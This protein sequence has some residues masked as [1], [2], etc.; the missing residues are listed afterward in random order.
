MAKSFH[1]LAW[2]DLESTNIPEPDREAESIDFSDVHIL[3][4]AVLISNMDLEPVTGYH[5]VVRMTP[6]AGESLRRNDFVRDMHMKNDLIRDCVKSESAK[7]LAEID[8]DLD[9]MF[10]EQ[11]SFEHGEFLIAGSGVSRFDHPLIDIRMPK[12]SRWLHYAELDISSFRRAST[13]YN[14]GETVTNPVP[15]SMRDGV[16]THRAWDD[17]QA[18][19]KE[20]QRQ[21]EF[22][23]QG[24]ETAN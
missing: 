17:V 23:R 21:A 8:D 16:K 11:T 2:C 20:A 1:S 3:E 4:V 5:E 18:H 24:F 9:K 6:E 19:L 22:V 10:R 7:T 13:I 12:F 14:H 15:E